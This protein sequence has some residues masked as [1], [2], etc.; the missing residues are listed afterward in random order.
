MSIAQ[1]PTADVSSRSRTPSR[2]R[3]RLAVLCDYPEEN[4]PSMDLAA[5]MLFRG[6]VQEHNEQFQ[7]EKICPTFRHRFS[8]V[9]WLGRRKVAHNAD[10]LLNRLWNYPKYLK[11]LANE[12]DVFH[13][14]DHS[15]SQVVHALPVDRTGVFCHDLDTFRCLLE[16]EK[17][18]RPWWFRKMAGHILRGMQKAALVFYTTNAVREEILRFGLVDPCKLIQAPLG[19]S[20]E[21]TPKNEDEGELPDSRLQSGPY[22]LHVG[23]CIPR[24]RMDVLLD[25]FAATR[26]THPELLLAKVGGPWT[27]AQQEQVDRLGLA[28][29]IV[30]MQ[31]LTRSQIATLYQKAQVVLLPSDAE[32]FGLPVIEAL[33]CGAVVV[34]SDI[35]V[36]REV[37]GDAVVYCPVGDVAD[38]SETLEQ[39][40][41]GTKGVPSREVRAA[42]A[43]LYSWETHCEKIVAA[44]DRMGRTKVSLL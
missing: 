19:V 23:S 35:P 41:R 43:R 44:Y 18:K 11:R 32:G 25:V 20:P 28:P 21:F 8:R 34:A 42:R 37:G 17:D 13:L 30:Q 22:L 9:P 29:S 2:P 1:Q 38:W 31:G 33:A 7:I 40:L 3:L 15:Y 5:D 26:K 4:W 14:C 6:L 16:P 10:R 36:L 39:I 12:F 27:P 24:K